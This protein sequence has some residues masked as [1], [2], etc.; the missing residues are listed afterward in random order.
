M[1]AK[2]KT[3]EYPKQDEAELKEMAEFYAK[4]YGEVWFVRCLNCMRI[5]AVEVPTASGNVPVRGR[6]I[7]GYQ[8][9]FITTRV[10]LDK[11]PD[12]KPMVGYECACGN[13]TR[14]GEVERGEVPVSTALVKKGTGEV[15]VPAEPP[16][17]L[18]PFER[19][20]LR[21]TVALK[22]AGSKKKAD[23]EINGTTE[24]FETFQLERVA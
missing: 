20:R 11:T 9:L 10:R 8:E 14:L 16:K 23:Y 1:V 15:V 24:R 2:S 7:Y 12:G 18:S 21:N 5:I 3:E 19:E 17:S 13:D 6:Q 4:Q 22:Q